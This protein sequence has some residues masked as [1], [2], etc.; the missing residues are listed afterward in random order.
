MVVVAVVVVVVVVMAA[1]A[2]AAVVP[3]ISTART[4]NSRAMAEGSGE[5]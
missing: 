3:G 2:A 4:A 5:W 1:A